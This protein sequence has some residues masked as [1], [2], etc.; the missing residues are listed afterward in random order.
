[1]SL[2]VKSGNVGYTNQGNPYQK[3]TIG[4]SIGTA[5]G[6]GMLIPATNSG[7]KRVGKSLSELVS[8]AKNFIKYGP[9]IFDFALIDSPKWEKF[10]DFAS[11]HKS[12][13][14]ATI[15]AMVSLPIML[16][17]GVGR[18]L[19]HGV[20]KIIDSGAKKQADIDAKSQKA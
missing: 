14:V 1:M 20:D 6:L 18:L 13:R 3:S 12:V 9:G 8:S 4:K 15:A 17:A 10:I 16:Y 11:K 5:A 19:G 2:S 7:V